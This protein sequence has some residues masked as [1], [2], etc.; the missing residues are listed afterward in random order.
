MAENR[1]EPGAQPQLRVI[2]G[3]GHT[4]RTAKGPHT[5]AGGGAASAVAFRRQHQVLRELIAPHGLCRLCGLV[6]VAPEIVR[7]AH[8]LA[9]YHGHGPKRLAKAIAKLLQ[10]VGRPPLEYRVFKRHLRGHVDLRLLPP[11]V[12]PDGGMQVLL[13][14]G[15][16]LPVEREWQ[17]LWRLY[18]SLASRVAEVDADPDAFTTDDGKFDGQRLA[19]FGSAIDKCRG[20]LADLGRLRKTESAQQAVVRQTIS[21][22]ST[23]VAGGLG[24][25]LRAAL[26]AARRGESVVDVLA[27]LVEGGGVPSMFMH[28]AEGTMAELQEHYRLRGGS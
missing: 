22:L 10:D 6:A 3:S 16:E 11:P 25:E 18:E 20:L 17:E 15:G 8:C 19:M 1:T 13:P 24:I 4:E 2:E 14:G 12:D 21:R 7:E 9:A 28:A 26:S 5:A 23:E 27:D